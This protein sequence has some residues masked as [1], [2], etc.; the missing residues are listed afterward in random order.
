[1]HGGCRPL[2]GSAQ[3]LGGGSAGTFPGGVKVLGHN[4]LAGQVLDRT[5][6]AL[7]LLRTGQ[8]VV[9]AQRTRAPEAAL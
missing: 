1:M 9:S 4:P 3:V 5:L 2:P 7:R 8:W 6:L